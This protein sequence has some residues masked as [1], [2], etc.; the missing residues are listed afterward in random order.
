MPVKTICDYRF[1]CSQQSVYDVEEK[2][3]LELAAVTA[4]KTNEVIDL[5]ND[6]EE[7][8]DAKADKTELAEVEVKVDSNTDQIFYLT[9][10]FSKGQT[11][12]VVNGGFFGDD[13]INEN[14]DGGNWDG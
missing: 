5:V 14:Y 12:F 10:Q 9:D 11:G 8:L 13:E 2:T 7:D 6:L 3:A 4:Q 1:P